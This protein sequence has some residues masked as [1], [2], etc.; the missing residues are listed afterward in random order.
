MET[1]VKLY[2]VKRTFSKEPRINVLHI[3]KSLGRG[4]AE[5]LLIETLNKHDKNRF[6]FHYIY[7]F[8]WKNQLVKEI[9]HEGGKV[10]CFDSKNN[11]Q[12]FLKLRRIASYIKENNIQLVHCHLP[13]AGITGRLAGKTGRSSRCLH[14]T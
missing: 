7:F 2:S 13:V 12:I 8:P 5:K 9:E 1:T 4:G 14:R 3:I 10:T 11:T 6:N